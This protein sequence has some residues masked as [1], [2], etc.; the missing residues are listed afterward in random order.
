MKKYA[1][2]NCVFINNSKLDKNYLNDSF[3][4]GD[5][6]TNLLI[7][8]GKISNFQSEKIRQYIEKTTEKFT[9]FESEYY[10]EKGKSNT[11]TAMCLDFYESKELDS[12]IKKIMSKKK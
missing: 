12:F 10:S 6:S 9:A 1:Y 11:I 2:C 7:D 8:L 4:I 5:K 3:Q